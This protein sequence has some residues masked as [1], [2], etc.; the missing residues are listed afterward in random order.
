[1]SL[2]RSLI[3]VCGALLQC[4]LAAAQNPSA[5]IQAKIV[6]LFQSARQ[7]EQRRDFAHA[8][9]LYDQILALDP[10]LAE[11]WTNKGLVLYE[12]DR[13]R[14]AL[15]AFAR[16]AALKP[17]LI[18]P[19]LFLGIE[20][21]KRGE[22]QKAIAPLEAVLAR[23]PGNRQAMYEL[24]E[25]CAHLERF[26]RAVN[27]YRELIGREPGME[28][29]SYRLGIAYLNWSKVAARKLVRAEPRSGWGELL[30]AEFEAVAGF[31]E[32]AK[33]NYR[34]AVVALPRAVEPRIA[35]ARFY[36][37]SNPPAAEEQL[38][39]AGELAP[40]AY[41]DLLANARHA[42]AKRE[43]AQAMMLAAAAWN[44][45]QTER[46]PEALVELNR[47]ARQDP[48]ALYRLSLVLRQLARQTFEEAVR[49][50]PD[51]YRAHLLLADLAR[52]ERDPDKARAEYAKA[53][54]LAPEDPEAHLLYIQFLVGARDVASALAAARRAIAKFSTHPALNTELGK[55]LLRSDQAQEAAA[56]FG[57]ALAADAT[58][59]DARAGLADSEA[60]MG[61]LE[62]AVAEMQRALPSD[63]D[64][65]L[66]YRLGRWYQKL[67]RERE[68]A[69]AFAQTT[70]L[71]EEK[72]KSELMQF[73]LT[74]E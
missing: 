39:K 17:A 35:L 58:L 69:E 21:V 29:A 11:V 14:E 7:A 31:L 27:L 40:P 12:L 30:L 53:V 56:C 50:N 32:D 46:T 25:A 48:H 60:A 6:P 59:A 52:G 61:E 44:T 16:A 68:A 4:F 23:E 24:A 63:T 70:R 33:R 1:M 66:H 15:Q 18:T 34:A 5:E 3:V 28:Q 47:Q 54:E 73:T 71:K 22:A 20:Y 37:E 13:H 10:K 72:G 49:R 36:L 8:A 62:K 42:L 38:A 51:S 43:V 2:D 19:Q 45:G 67:G 55:M 74:R 9:Q 64:G 57:R 65:S 41:R 26:E